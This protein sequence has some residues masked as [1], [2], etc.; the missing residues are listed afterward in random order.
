MRN[1]SAGSDESCTAAATAASVAAPIAANGTDG[2]DPDNLAKGRDRL[3]TDAAK[4]AGTET[5]V[6]SAACATM[7]IAAPS[8]C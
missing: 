1:H 3:A 8:A 2:A 5:Q 7:L 6:E 4:K